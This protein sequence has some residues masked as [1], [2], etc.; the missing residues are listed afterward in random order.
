MKQKVS[1]FCLTALAFALFAGG[2]AFTRIQKL[3]GAE[4][5][6]HARQMNVLSS[7]SWTS[8]IGS[9]AE[10]VYLEY[11]YPASTGKG[12]RTTVYWTNLT[13]LPEEIANKIRATPAH[14]KSWY[15]DDTEE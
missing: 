1:I 12:T 6:E 13:E 4:F 3:S 15:S 11:A 14:D 7:F 8:Y 2:C 10:R 5:I 9:T